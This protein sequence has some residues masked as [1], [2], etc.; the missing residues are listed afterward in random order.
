MHL[1][2]HHTCTI[3]ATVLIYASNT[4][5]VTGFYKTVV[6]NTWQEIMVSL[7][8]SI[9]SSVISDGLS[10]DKETVMAKNSLVDLGIASTI[11]HNNQTIKLLAF[12]LHQHTLGTATYYARLCNAHSR[13][14]QVSFALIAYLR[15]S[16]MCVLLALTCT[17]MFT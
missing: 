11:Y 6:E 14:P 4:K 5:S 1:V 17:C 15:K 2:C 13:I 3:A 8:I 9:L 10:M 7:L 12:C 16:S